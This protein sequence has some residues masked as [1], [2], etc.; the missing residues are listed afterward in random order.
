MA[1]YLIM[2]KT[3]IHIFPSFILLDGHWA[4]SAAT[5]SVLPCPTSPAHSIMPAFTCP[6]VCIFQACLCWAGDPLLSFNCPTCKSKGGNSGAFSLHWHWG[7]WAQRFFIGRVSG[8]WGS[9][10]SANR[11]GWGFTLGSPGPQPLQ[12]CR[13]VFGDLGPTCGRP[14][15][16]YLKMQGATWLSTKALSPHGHSFWHH[17]HLN[18]Q[19]LKLPDDSSDRASNLPKGTGIKASCKWTY[20]NSHPQ[21]PANIEDSREFF[22]YSS[23]FQNCENFKLNWHLSLKVSSNPLHVSLIFLLVGGHR[24]LIR[25]TFAV[26]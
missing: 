3:W 6:N 17:L 9:A 20:P 16:W 18:S 8:P 25:G 12:V 26:M 10:L 19:E 7:H 22:F 11:L 15:I 23:K 24:W 1:H 21:R 4:V 13:K 5:V 14:L 2:W